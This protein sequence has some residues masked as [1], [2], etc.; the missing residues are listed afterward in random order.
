LGFQMVARVLVVCGFWSG[1]RNSFGFGQGIL[2]IGSFDCARL[3]FARRAS[4]RTTLVLD[5]DG[6]TRP[7]RQAQ[8]RAEAPLFHFDTLAIVALKHLRHPNPKSQRRSC[9]PFTVGVLFALRGRVM[10]GGRFI[11]ETANMRMTY[12]RFLLSRFVRA[13]E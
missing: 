9:G 6:S 7:L 5:G 8:G 10:Q 12:S 3:R 4:L 1:D 13:S 2:A 11:P